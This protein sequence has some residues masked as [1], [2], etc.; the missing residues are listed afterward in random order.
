[1]GSTLNFLPPLEPELNARLL[2]MAA[3][4]AGAE[5]MTLLNVAYTDNVHSYIDLMR[6]DAQQLVEGLGSP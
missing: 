3:Q 2:E 4:D 5:V 6:F 1:M